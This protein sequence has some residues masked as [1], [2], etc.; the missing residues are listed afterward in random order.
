MRSLHV[1]VVLT[2]ARC[3]A[4]RLRS[5]TRL[6]P[7]KRTSGCLPERV[8]H[9]GGRTSG[10]LPT[11]RA[12]AAR[13]MRHWPPRFQHARQRLKNVDDFGFV[14]MF[15]HAEIPKAVNPA[16]GFEQWVVDIPAPRKRRSSNFDFWRAIFNPSGEMS[17]HQKSGVLEV[18]A[19]V[20]FAAAATRRGGRPWRFVAEILV[21]IMFDRGRDDAAG[22]RTWQ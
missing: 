8:C 22:G 5:R 1:Q 4:L 6:R 3:W 13:K 15:H 10:R 19:V 12:R 11:V 16:G 7:D 20:R 18:D 14:K 17:H 2:P 9:P 21:K